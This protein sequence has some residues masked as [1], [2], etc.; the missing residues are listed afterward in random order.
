ML[1]AE[2]Q[3]ND[4]LDQDDERVLAE[5]KILKF[6]VETQTYSNRDRHHGQIRL[7]VFVWG[8]KL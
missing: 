2:L 3:V 4:F 6:L 5:G 7:H 8:P 1:Q